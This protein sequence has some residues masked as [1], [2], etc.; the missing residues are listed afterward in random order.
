M[1]GGFKGGRAWEASFERFTPPPGVLVAVAFLLCNGLDLFFP[2][3]GAVEAG[4]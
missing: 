4:A 3:A 1:G 2:E